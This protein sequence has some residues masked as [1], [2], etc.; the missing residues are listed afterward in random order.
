M[1]TGAFYGALVGANNFL[2]NT[3]DPLELLSEDGWTVDEAS[4]MTI[5]DGDAVCDPEIEQG[6]IEQVLDEIYWANAPLKM[7]IV[8]SSITQGDLLV[9]GPDIAITTAGTYVVYSDGLNIFSINSYNF[10]DAVIDTLS[11]KL[12]NDNQLGPELVANGDFSS[13]TGWSFQGD[14]NLAI[15]GGKLVASGPPDEA[16]AVN[17]GTFDINSLYKISYE[18]SDYVDGTLNGVVGQTSAGVFDDDPTFDDSSQ[19]EVMDYVT[20][21]NNTHGEIA[22]WFGNDSDMSIDNFSV[23]KYT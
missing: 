22:L 21:T 8:V 14:L 1:T 12:L 20:T 13:G 16:Y 17:T 6:Y 19:D 2:V 4:G 18:V 15:T 23:R 7:T 10:C 5:V 9:N 3:G 11:L